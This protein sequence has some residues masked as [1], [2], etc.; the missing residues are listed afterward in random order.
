VL[1]RCGRT[2]CADRPG[3]VKAPQ[4]GDRTD[5]G[6]DAARGLVPGDEGGQELW[7]AAVQRFRQRQDGSEDRH[8]RVTDQGCV[9]IVEVED[10][11]R[12]P[13]DQ[14]GVSRADPDRIA[15]HT[16]PV[17]DG[18]G[19]QCLQQ[20]AWCRFVASGQGHAQPVQNTQP[21]HRDDIGG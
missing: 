12:R 4:I 2:E 18:A 21:G 11:R 6:G 8:R 17:L 10:M 16:G 9:H 3:V 1:S 15:E 20:D 5:S 19:R 14:R 7:S 13:I